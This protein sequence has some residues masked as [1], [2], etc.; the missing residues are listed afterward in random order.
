MGTTPNY[1]IPYP[2]PADD[3][4]NDAAAT[5]ILAEHLDDALAPAW[6][7]FLHY[8]GT[9]QNASGAGVTIDWPGTPGGSGHFAEAGGVL[10]YTGPARPF[11]ISASLSLHGQEAVQQVVDLYVG[12]AIRRR[13]EHVDQS[14]PAGFAGWHTHSL[15]WSGILTGGTTISVLATDGT[16]API[17][18]PSLSVCSIGPGA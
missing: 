7:D 13:S 11:I 10:T 17:Y 15:A 8:A 12:G 14:D 3:L 9:T 6:H 5:R 16:N 1:A 4:R 18:Y 2:E